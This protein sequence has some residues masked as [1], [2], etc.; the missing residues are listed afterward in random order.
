[1]NDYMQRE[2]IN[3]LKGHSRRGRDEA[4]LITGNCA[5][6]TADVSQ[7][8]YERIA[9]KHMAKKFAIMSTPLPAILWPCCPIR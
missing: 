8:A 9:F 2:K 5:A 4:A 1:V 7:L 6:I 3:F